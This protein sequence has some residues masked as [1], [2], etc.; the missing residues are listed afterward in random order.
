MLSISDFIIIHKPGIKNRTNR[1][2]KESKPMN[3][4]QT[5]KGQES[6][7]YKLRWLVG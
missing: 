4:S 3:H 5:S 2:S 1:Y 7:Q 6:W